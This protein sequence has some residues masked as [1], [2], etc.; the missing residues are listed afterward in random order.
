MSLGNQRVLQPEDMWKIDPSR[1]SAVLA[2][3]LMARFN[4][5]RERVER[6]NAS[7][8]S[9]E[10]VPSTSTK[11]WWRVRKSVFGVGRADGRREVGLFGALSDTFFWQFWSAGFLKLLADLAQ[12]FSPLVT[13]ALITYAT[14]AYYFHRGVPGYEDR[15]VGEGVGM[16][17]GLWAMQ[18]FFSTLLHQ[19]FV[20][21][22]GVGVLA[23]AA[24]IAAIYR[25][26]M[27]LSPKARTT[28]TNGK[29]VNHISTDVSRI[30]FAAGFAHMSWTSAIVFIVIVVILIIELGPSSLAGVGFLVVM[31]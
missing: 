7:L 26:A 8:D 21:S 19:F 12:V 20:R 2:D 23:R 30:D 10:Y 27:R 3:K 14:S 24:L 6:W 4:A 31:M 13:R 17:I 29:L 1:E 16:A 11:A 25:H 15:G 28:V 5:R 22:M 9:G 18:I